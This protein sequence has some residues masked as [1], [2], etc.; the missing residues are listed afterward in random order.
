LG[1]LLPDNVDIFWTGNEVCAQSITG[2]D[3]GAI[4]EQLG[5]PPLLWDNYP[6]NDGEKASRRLN[7]APLPARDPAL[8]GQLSGHLCNPMNQGLLSRLPLEGLAGLYH[9]RE[10]STAAEFSER[11]MQRIESDQARFQAAGLDGLEEGERRELVQIYSEFED[12][13]ATEIVDW[14][15]GGYAFDPACLTG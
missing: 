7:L 12:P 2:A 10:G 15:E 5:R 3:I 8:P 11:F 13:A 1:R 9:L 14:L 4:S 6:V